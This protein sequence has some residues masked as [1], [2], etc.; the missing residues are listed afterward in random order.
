MQ[1][2]ERI[3]FL[4]K[5]YDLSAEDVAK[6]IGVSRATV[7]RYETKEVENMPITIL[8]PLSKVL[9][10]SPAYLMG[11][12]NESSPDL[13]EH[14]YHLCI[15]EELLLSDFRTLN[16]QGQDYIL[17]TMD[18]VKDKYKKSNL[19]SDMEEIV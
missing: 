4:R 15:K 9:H 5:K 3:K 2:Y 11:W 16:E 12:E 1:V 8:E 13:L 10:C 14:T 19:L 7:Y 18:M 17:Q 6:A